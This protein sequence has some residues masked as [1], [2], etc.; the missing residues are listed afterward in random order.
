[1]TCSLYQPISRWKKS[2]GSAPV[3]R[4]PEWTTA[5]L[6]GQRIVRSFPPVSRSSLEFPVGERFA[7]AGGGDVDVDLRYLDAGHVEHPTG[8]LEGL[9]VCT[10]ENQPLGCLDGVLIEPST[11]RVRYF[12][13]DP[14]EPSQE[15]CMLAADAPVVL[16]I[17]GRTLRVGPG[18]DMEPLQDSQPF[19]DED[20]MTA[21][22]RNTAA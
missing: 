13:V 20:V 17:R 2:N 11:R 12:V 14:T 7:I 15:R 5:D 3:S 1:M 10:E 16:D 4:G 6:T 22:F 19:S 9:S 8:T 18:A 21:L